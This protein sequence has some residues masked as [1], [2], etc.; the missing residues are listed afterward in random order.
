MFYFSLSCIFMTERVNG[1]DQKNA[2]GLFIEI[3]KEP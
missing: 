2:N 3:S 1:W